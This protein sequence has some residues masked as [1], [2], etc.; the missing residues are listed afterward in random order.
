MQQQNIEGSVNLMRGERDVF[1]PM[2][3]NIGI[4]LRDSTTTTTSYDEASRNEV[5]CHP[6]HCPFACHQ[7]NARRRAYGQWS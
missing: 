5:L 6:C 7:Y 2:I 3:I 4:R 1:Y